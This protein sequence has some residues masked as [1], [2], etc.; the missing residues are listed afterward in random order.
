LIPSPSAFFASQLQWSE[1]FPPH[2]LQWP[3]PPQAPSIRAQ[4]PWTM[5]K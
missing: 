3:A 4:W 1:Q 5:P 2:L